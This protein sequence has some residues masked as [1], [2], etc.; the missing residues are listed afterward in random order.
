MNDPVIL[1][2]LDAEASIPNQGITSRTL[3]KDDTV[4]VVLFGFD[5]GQELSEHT[6]S[7]P[8]TIH[9][10]SGDATVNIGGK[11]AEAGPGFWA[12]MPPNM[13][14]SILAKKPTVMLL[15]MIQQRS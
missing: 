14:H 3:H 13:R 15:Y 9:I 12:W 10:L 1:P 11:V 6:A 2:D 4:K 7:V 8:A 5:T